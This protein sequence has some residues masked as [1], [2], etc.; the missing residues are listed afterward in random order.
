VP[1]HLLVPAVAAVDAPDRR[2]VAR[3]KVAVLPSSRIVARNRKA[4]APLDVL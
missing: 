1:V 4:A 2:L 3:S